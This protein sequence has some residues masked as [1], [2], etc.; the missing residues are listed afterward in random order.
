MIAE[1]D[2]I[3]TEETKFSRWSQDRFVQDKNTP[4]YVPWELFAVCG[5][6]AMKIFSMRALLNDMNRL[7]EERN[8]DLFFR[9]K[10][11]RSPEPIYNPK[12]ERVNTRERRFRDKKMKIVHELLNMSNIHHNLPPRNGMR[13]YEKKIYFTKEFLETTSFRVIIGPR[14]RTQKQLE[15]E[16]GCFI[17]VRGRGTQNN[18]RPIGRTYPGDDD[19]PHVLISANTEDELK[20]GVEKVTWLLSDSPD[21][22]LWRAEKLR[23]LSIINGTFRDLPDEILRAHQGPKMSPNLFTKSMTE[24]DAEY[25]DFMKALLDDEDTKNLATL[26]H[27]PPAGG[28]PTSPTSPGEPTAPT[29][30][31]DVSAPIPNLPATRGFMSTP[32]MASAPRP[33]VF[34]QMQVPM[35]PQPNSPMSPLGGGMPPPPFGQPQF[36]G[37]QQVPS[38]PRGPMHPMGGHFGGPPMMGAPMSPMMPGA[39]RGPSFPGSPSLGYPAFARGPMMPPRGPFG[40]GLPTYGAPDPSQPSSPGMYGNFGAPGWAPPHSPQAPPP[41]A[42]IIDHSAA[43]AQRPVFGIFGQPQ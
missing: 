33:P 5:G 35:H 23:E 24:C 10:R 36:R 1:P 8:W 9:R 20:K 38:F 26:I 43:P 12:G 15:G 42:P 30:P 6:E 7:T 14:G 18:L 29:Q 40:T 31:V 2:P 25:R 19:D 32:M 4:H 39:F 28:N 17:T 13:K 37:F 16:T 22:Q 11:A 41:G 34:P 27:D 3:F 21:A